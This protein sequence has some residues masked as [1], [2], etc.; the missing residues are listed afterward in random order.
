VALR[1]DALDRLMPMHL[2]ID[3]QGRVRAAGPTL[4]KL[5]PA[6]QWLGMP[7][8][9]LFA[10]RR[11]RAPAT[12]D[13]LRHR[14]GQRLHLAPLQ[15]PDLTLRG[16]A[17]PVSG[18]GIALNLSFGIWVSEAVR[19]YRLTVAD[20]AATDLTVEMLYL[21]EAKS[22]VM[23]ELRSLNL[24]LNGARIA[25]E[26]QAL[27]DTLTGLRNRRA[28]DARMAELISAGQAFGMM[29]ID[30]DFFKQVNDIL[31][32]A[33][34]DHVLR[35][36]ATVLGEEIRNSDMAARVGGDEF[37]LLFPGLSD[38]ARLGQIARRIIERLTGPME[39]EG[40]ACRISAS[41]GITLSNLYTAPDAEQLMADADQA[42]YASKR[43][44]RGQ[45]QLY[46]AQG[47][48]RV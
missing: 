3:A 48:K 21:V 36:V 30:L 39:F 13:A 10:L 40:K 31:G 9:K 12:V 42:T 28:M 1:P 33:A 16:L 41:I 24:R 32:H 34:G 20:F 17:V 44:G 22:A 47:I 46:T 26:E 38:V 19:R 4:A 14:I 7:L 23:D 35:E 2:R 11:P 27:T 29:H 5:L 25:A 37:V 8:E 18:G 43:G 15:D 45:A 6:G